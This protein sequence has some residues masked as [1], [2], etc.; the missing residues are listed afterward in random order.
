MLSDLGLVS[1]ENLNFP[2]W[3]KT[4]FVCSVTVLKP[5]AFFGSCSDIVVYRCQ[6]KPNRWCGW[7]FCVSL[8]FGVGVC[9]SLGPFHPAR[10]CW[11]L[12]WMEVIWECSPPPIAS[13]IR[14]GLLHFWPTLFLY[15]TSKWGK[16][17]V[18]AHSL[19]GV[20]QALLCA[21]ACTRGGPYGSTYMTQ[22]C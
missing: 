14:S 17:S 5:F 20:C 9:Y 22:N 2:L 11:K 15:C 10:W 7:Q 3:N 12:S 6:C 13:D 18:N 16:G 4:G 1:S 21:Q 19:T 8:T